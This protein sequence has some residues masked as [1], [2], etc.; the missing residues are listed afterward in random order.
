MSD[1]DADIIRVRHEGRPS[2][3]SVGNDRESRRRRRDE[4]IRTLLKLV[5]EASLF[6]LVLSKSL[7]AGSQ[8]KQQQQQLLQTQQTRPGSVVDPADHKLLF[9][10]VVS[11]SSF[12]LI[13][14]LTKLVI[15]LERITPEKKKARIPVHSSIRD[16]VRAGYPRNKRRYRRKKRRRD[17]K[18][19]WK[20]ILR[21]IVE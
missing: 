9:F 16:S 17:R 18:E 10:A 21:T 4:S 1:V 3:E 2:K 6:L 14:V 12:P 8:Q 20:P 11:V 13:W 15:V 7:Q 5:F 19:S